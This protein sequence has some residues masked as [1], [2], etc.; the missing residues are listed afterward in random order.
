MK[1]L[2]FVS[3]LQNKMYIHEILKKMRKLMMIA[4]LILLNNMVMYGQKNNNPFFAEYSTPYG[5][6]PF[7]KIDTSHYV[8]AF[9][10]GI[11][12]QQAEIDAIVNNPA[13]ATFEN[14][15]L[16]FDQSGELLDKVGAVFY[17]LNSANTDAVMQEIARKVSPMTTTHSDNI[18]LNAKLFQRIKA[19]YETRLSSG[20]DAQQIRVTEKYY[21]DFVRN[22]ANLNAADQDKLRKINQ[23]LSELQLQ[24]GENLLAETNEN[25]RLV[26]ENKN[27]LKGLPEDV[28]AGAAEAA[29]KLHL[30]G[31]WVFT[32]AKPSMIPFLQYADNRELR[33]KLYRGYFMRGNNG[34]AYDNKKIMLDILNLRCQKAKLLGFRDFASY[35]ISNNMAG[36]PEKVYDFLGQVMTPALKAA[37]RDRDRAARAA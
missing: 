35:I 34:N 12:D 22:G 23:Q 3:A 1:K 25:F 29:K 19:V 36:T 6:P 21:D 20:L 31:K 13:P 9:I 16:A 26:I 8:P 5:V 7:D 18:M 10:K 11:A 24:F 33:E 28:I 32:L 15:I 27:D 37:V 17:S 30:D 4:L 2:I 14:T